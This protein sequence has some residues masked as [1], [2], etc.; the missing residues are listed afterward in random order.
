M[1]AGQSGVCGVATWLGVAAL[2]VGGFAGVCAP[3]ASAEASR[4]GAQ[5]G[6]EQVFDADA[7]LDQEQEKDKKDEKKDEKK[8]DKKDE[9]KGLPLKPD[10]K[11]TFTTDEGWK[12][13]CV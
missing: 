6:Y 3:G 12:D 5:A 8:D 13:R 11:I 9:K 10:R 2:V 1:I 7:K 4:M